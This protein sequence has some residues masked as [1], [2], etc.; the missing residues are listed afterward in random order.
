MIV[1]ELIFR[2]DG[3]VC[4]LGNSF[5]VPEDEAHELVLTGNYKYADV[6]LGATVGSKED[7]DN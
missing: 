4:A 6:P 7:G 5:D 2:D 1:Y 3:T